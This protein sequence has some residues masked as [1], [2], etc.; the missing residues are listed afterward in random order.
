MSG[1][2]VVVIVGV[3]LIVQVLRGDAL[4]RLKLVS[5]S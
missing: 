4:A 5:S 2:L 1:G 3:V